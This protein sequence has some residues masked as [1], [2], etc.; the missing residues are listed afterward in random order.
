MQYLRNIIQ[1]T[2]RLP[3]LALKYDVFVN[4]KFQNYN[5]LVIIN[6]V[7]PITFTNQIK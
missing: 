2:C 6:I 1:Q 7:L 5:K 3:S 4:Y